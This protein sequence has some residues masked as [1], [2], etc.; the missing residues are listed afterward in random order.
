VEALVAEQFAGNG[1]EGFEMLSIGLEPG[2]ME[3][4]SADMLEN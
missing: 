2:N 4:L 3:I 1:A